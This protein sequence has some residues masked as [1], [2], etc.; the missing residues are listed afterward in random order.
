MEAQKQFIPSLWQKEM[1][2]GGHRIIYL[3]IS[4]LETWH[5]G[6]EFLL[7][8]CRSMVVRSISNF[9][10]FCIIFFPKDQPILIYFKFSI[11]DLLWVFRRIRLQF[12]KKF[13]PR[14]CLA[15]Y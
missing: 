1:F 14:M 13:V 3:I 11:I 9:I 7:M 5:N 10:C 12:I 2:L 6:A 4:S 8:R 15:L